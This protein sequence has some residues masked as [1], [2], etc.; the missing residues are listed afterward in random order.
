MAQVST[1]IAVEDRGQ[2]TSEDATASVVE[3]R[4]K[5]IRL[6]RSH[7][8]PLVARLQRCTVRAAHNRAR[9]AEGSGIAR[10]QLAARTRVY[11]RL[12]VRVVVHTLDDINLPR[13]RPSRAFGPECRPSPTARGHV[14]AVHDDKPAGESE[15]CLDAH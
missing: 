10:W 7:T 8:T 11:G 4:A 15:L 12:V 14:Y 5:R 6:T 2:R 13:Q 3:R 9:D 1:R